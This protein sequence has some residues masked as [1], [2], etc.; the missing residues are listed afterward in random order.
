MWKMIRITINVL[1]LSV[2]CGLLL[3][4]CFQAIAAEGAD[5]EDTGCI[6]TIYDVEAA[7]RPRIVLPKAHDPQRTPPESRQTSPKLSTLIPVPVT[8][9]GS[10]RVLLCLLRINR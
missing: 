10:A 5:S 6:S 2:T 9:S 1:L 8:S 3:S 7:A 4:P